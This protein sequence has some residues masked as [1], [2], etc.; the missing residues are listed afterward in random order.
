MESQIV[1]KNV[2][3]LTLFKMYIVYKAMKDGWQVSRISK[4]KFVFTKRLKYPKRFSLQ[5]F[6]E[7]YMDC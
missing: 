3:N 1:S 7:K 6:L 2:N 5:H 4:R